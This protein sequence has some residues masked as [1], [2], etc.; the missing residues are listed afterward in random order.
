MRE[1][2][3]K[4]A[5]VT[6]A[7][8]NIG[9]AISVA[10]AEAGAS[11]VVNTKSSLDHAAETVRLVQATGAKAMLAQ[12]DVTDP[13][14][15]ANMVRQ[16]D[17]AFGGID[18]LVNNAAIRKEGLLETVTLAEWRQLLAVILDGAFLCT[19]ACVPFMRKRGGGAIV[20][21]GGMTGHSGAKHRVHVVTAKAG[22]AGF[23]KAIAH[24]LAA[25]KITA[26][27]VVPGMLDTKRDG[28]Q[29][30]HHRERALLMDRLGEASEV[31]ALVRFLCGPQATYITGQSLHINGGVLMP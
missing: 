11:V 26:N 24:D 30:K 20:N 18:I 1:L 6:G 13:A 21:I 4:V 22:L 14:A 31:A 9:R 15:V 3:G 16:A 17:E 25:D 7:A 19:Q 10:L 27:C 2:D 28:A 8:R 12:A 23:T 29:P 5:L